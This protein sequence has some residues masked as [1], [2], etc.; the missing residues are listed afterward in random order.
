MSNDL[1][2]FLLR[3][4]VVDNTSAFGAFILGLNPSI[5]TKKRNIC[6]SLFFYK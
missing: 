6:V 4:G 5:A 2:G 3:Y 1:A